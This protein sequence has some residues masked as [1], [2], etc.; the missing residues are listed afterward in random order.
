MLRPLQDIRYTFRQLAK[1]P[2]FTIVS[3]LTIALGIGANA[4]I[5]SVMNAVLLRFLPVSNPQQLV[6]FHLRNQPL[7][8]SQTGFGDLSMSLPVFEAMRD[9][10][11]VFSDV[12]AFA[13]LAFGKLAVRVGA[14]P[15]EA[16]GEL[17]SGNYFPALGVRPVLGRGFTA[18]D[19]SDHASVA[20]LSFA[21]WNRRFA[22]APDVLGRTFYVKG[23]P[24]TIVGVAPAGFQGTDPGHPGM[25]FWIP[26]QRRPELS[27]NGT[28]PSDHTLY[29]S[30]EWLAL[31]LVGRLRPGISP[32][33]A[34][35]QLTAPF[36]NALANASPAGPNEPKPDVF[37]TSL[38]GV[39]NLKGYEEPLHFLMYMVGV[40]LLIAC[41][42]VAMLL[43][44][45]N[46]GR[47]REF[48]LRQALGAG[49]R[50]LF[51]QLLLESLTLV[52]AGAA[53]GWLFAGYATQAL[54]AW[55][56]IGILLAP[57]RTVLW[58]TLAISAAI[59]ILFGLAPLRT[60]SRVPLNI[61]LKSAAATAHTDPGRLWGRKLVIALQ[62][63]LCTVLMFAAGLL[64]RTLR[65]LEARDLGMRTNGVLV[66]GIEPQSIHSDAEAVRF[67]TRL[68]DR[69]RALPG[70]DSATVTQVRLGM[71]ASNNDG[72][73]VDGRK[74]MPARPF[75]PIRTNPA[76]RSYAR[77][78]SRCASAATS[79][80]PTRSR[81][82]KSP[83][84]TRR[85]SSAICQAWTRS[86]VASHRRSAPESITRS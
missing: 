38:R 85:S 24:L 5:F 8:T 53:L 79:R 47:Q 63:S 67:H 82:L 50:V 18:W 69:M 25:D 68:L 40:I 45:R 76:P 1:S 43:I 22:A 78:G 57:D 51:L 80:I 26:L 81:P 14:E 77:S 29:G 56:G 71:H 41:A 73:L 28:P 23:V 16:H 62:I 48:G 6:F 17:V 72:I 70:V 54:S 35:A 34:A 10:H 44:A 42:N 55:S 3:V 39:E 74:P 13:P 11:E 84:S 66:F 60:V 19:E 32:V 20:V 37:F 15:E 30:P 65:N 58:F 46:A 33:Q 52:T 4:A 75:A 83:S 2:A 86:V 64:Y 12:I 7:S 31:V 27:P 9:R 59:A 36:R 49:R 61:A 21:Y